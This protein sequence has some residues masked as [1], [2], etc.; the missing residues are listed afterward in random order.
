M[1]HIRSVCLYVCVCVALVIQH[2]KRMRLIALSSVT[3]L[4][5]PHFFSHYLI[6]GTTFG[7]KIIEYKMCVLGEE[8]ETNKMQ[9]I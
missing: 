7:E 9:L 2:E 5:L 8:R 3:C 4:V 6:A 1:L